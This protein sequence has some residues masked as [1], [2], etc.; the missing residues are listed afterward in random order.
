MSND[1]RDLSAGKLRREQFEGGN[2][3]IHCRNCR[4]PLDMTEQDIE[5]NNG[6]CDHCKSKGFGARG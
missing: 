5:E 4:K 2:V 3:V 6:Y 1:F